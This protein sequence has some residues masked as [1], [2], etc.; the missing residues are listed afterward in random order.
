MVSFSCNACG[1]TVRKAQVERHYQNECP[2]CNVLSCIDCGNDFYGD[3]YTTHTSC[4]SEA[5]KYQGKLYK[6]KDKQNKGEQRQ[7]QWVKQ[8]RDAIT[9]GTIIIDRR[10]D[11][12]LDRIS[13]YANIPRKKAK[14]QN[15]CKNSIN[16]QDSATLDKLW[17]VFS[18]ASKQSSDGD[19]KSSDGNENGE[20]NKATPYG[21]SS[22]DQDESSGKKFKKRKG[23]ELKQCLSKEERKK[24]KDSKKH[25]EE[26][27]KDTDQP[28]N[29]IKLKGKRKKHNDCYTNGNSGEIHERDNDKK[30]Q[31]RAREEEDGNSDEFCTQ[32]KV[33]KV[34]SGE[35]NGTYHFK[36]KSVIKAVL[37]ESS[38]HELPIKRLRK[39]VLTEFQAQGANYKNLTDNELQALFEKKV[40]SNPKFKVHKDRVRL[41]K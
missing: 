18:S 16:V 39:K 37:K 25:K 20:S 14:F 40:K 31:K 9:S 11:S 21:D 12:L 8:V 32:S 23:K 35:S 41:V 19:V 3:E 34:E 29:G 15:F 26:K 30:K 17:E 10:L 6:P 1:K 13:D 33:S 5:E 7:Q 22:D 2:D 24:T 36:W 27:F 38:D 4:I 28:E